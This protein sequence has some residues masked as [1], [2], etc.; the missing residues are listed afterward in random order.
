MSDGLYSLWAYFRPALAHQARFHTL[1]TLKKNI[2]DEF[3]V[4][5]DSITLRAENDEQ[6]W[7]KNLQGTRL[8]ISNFKGA[9]LKDYFNF[10]EIKRLEASSTETATNDPS[11]DFSPL[12]RILYKNQFQLGTDATDYGERQTIVSNRRRLLEKIF[13]IENKKEQKAASTLFTASLPPASRAEYRTPTK[14]ELATFN[15]LKEAIEQFKKKR[16]PVKQEDLD[17]AR[18][19][20]A[21]DAP[22]PLKKF[23]RALIDFLDQNPGVSLANLQLYLNQYDTNQT[24]PQASQIRQGLI[25]DDPI[26]E[27]R[28]SIQRNPEI[29]GTGK[30]RYMIDQLDMISAYPQLSTEIAEIGRTNDYQQ[31]F[32]QLKQLS[33]PTSKFFD[34][35]LKQN[36]L[37]NETEQKFFINQLLG[38]FTI[39]EANNH[40]LHQFFTSLGNALQNDP[41][42]TQEASTLKETALQILQTNKSNEQKVKPRQ[43][44][45]AEEPLLSGDAKNLLSL[46]VLKL[47]PLEEPEEPINQLQS[48]SADQTRSVKKTKAKEGA[49]LF[50]GNLNRLPEEKQ[51]IFRPILQTF[52]KELLQLTEK[53]QNIDYLATLQKFNEELT[54]LANFSFTDLTQ[55]CQAFRT[56][57]IKDS[58]AFDAAVLLTSVE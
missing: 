37:L 54:N 58:S 45:K 46:A 25:P 40:D 47:T 50:E 13:T 35:D 23:E 10:T 56:S 57:L 3:R 24:S 51:F 44:Q 31:F 33:Y 41:I 4:L 29:K 16:F 8:F 18:D 14:S 48:S 43:D 34:S 52:A 17:R 21:E 36:I 26:R 32:V 7:T 12:E 20:Q 5:D 9:N 2:A 39:G 42:D 49:E 19:A 22:D 6:K 11:A 28:R 30:E 27:V 55:K 15:Q 53:N 1:D 38:V